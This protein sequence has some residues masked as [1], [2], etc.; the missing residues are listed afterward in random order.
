MASDNTSTQA[1]GTSRRKSGPKAVW[2]ADD[3]K[4]IV[5]AESNEATRYSVTAASSGEF[6]SEQLMEFNAVGSFSMSSSS[7]ELSKDLE[8]QATCHDEIALI[9]SQVISRDEDF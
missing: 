1:A 9:Y 5:S 7:P 3:D 6:A 2:T 4:L 8:Y